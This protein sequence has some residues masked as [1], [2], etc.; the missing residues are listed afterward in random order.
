MRKSVLFFAIFLIFSIASTIAAKPCSAEVRDFWF[1]ISLRDTDEQ[2]LEASAK[3][4]WEIFSTAARDRGFVIKPN[5][6]PFT[7]ARTTVVRLDTPLGEI[8]HSGRELVAVS[9]GVG[10]LESVT[11]RRMTDDAVAESTQKHTVGYARGRLAEELVYWESGTTKEARKLSAWDAMRLESFA[12]VLS[13]HAAPPSVPTA[14]ALLFFPEL[15]GMKLRFQNLYPQDSV[16]T[17][18]IIFA[19]GRLRFGSV[20]DTD[21]L[22]SYWKDLSSH[23]MVSGSVSWELTLGEFVTGEEIGLAQSFF[24]LMQERLAKA[25]LIVPAL[26]WR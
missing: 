11:L 2:S 21:I 4:I 9:D 7:P 18:K 22:I 14:D 24:F 13:K 25:G 5:H 16:P 15:E 10:A 8:A 12:P 23:R 20:L 3:K 19:P 6:E 1:H 17:Q 26:K